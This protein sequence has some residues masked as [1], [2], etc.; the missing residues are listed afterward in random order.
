M[1]TT[2]YGNGTCNSDGLCVCNTDNFDQALNCSRCIEGHWGIDCDEGTT[3]LCHV[4]ALKF[5]T[6]C[7]PD[8]KNKT[9]VCAERGKCTKNGT[10]ECD[11]EA[12][13]HFDPN[14]ACQECLSGWGGINCEM[15]KFNT[16]HLF[17]A[18]LLFQ[19]FLCS[20][21]MRVR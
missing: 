2:C 8:E 12:Y 7:D 5:T 19:K 9:L 15:G 21:V 18:N 13:P 4:M 20:A 6:V 17:D 1:A 11:S 10:C 14:T 3:L 16:I